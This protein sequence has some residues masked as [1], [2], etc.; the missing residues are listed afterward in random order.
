M[1]KGY[2][3]AFGEFKTISNDIVEHMTQEEPV[4]AEHVD[5]PDGYVCMPKDIFNSM[6]SYIDDMPPMHGDMHGDMPP[7]DGDMPQIIDMPPMDGDMPQI[8]DKPRMDGDMPQII[9]KPRM[10]GD[11]PQIIDKP[12]MDGDMP[13]II[14]KPRMDGDMP[15]I[16]DKP[17][18][19]GTAAIVAK[20]LTASTYELNMQKCA[21]DLSWA[22]QN[23]TLCRDQLCE[24]PNFAGG[25]PELCMPGPDE[26]VDPECCHVGPTGMA[27]DKCFGIKNLKENVVICGLMMHI[28]QKMKVWRTPLTKHAVVL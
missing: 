9:D 14:D 12:R 16:I 18:M 13:Q 28:S 6:R 20:D 21:D 17:R 3:T 26:D 1:S 7:M 5:C 23:Q 4:K 11:M 2:Y 22:M 15:Q 19:D 27:A 10:D 8:I 24:D 25:N